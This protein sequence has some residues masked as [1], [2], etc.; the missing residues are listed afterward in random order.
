MKFTLSWLKEHLDTDA[1]VDKIA[2]TL[3]IPQN[4]KRIRCPL[5]GR[6]IKNVIVSP[7]NTMLIFEYQAM[8]NI[9]FCN[10][11]LP[12]A[13]ASWQTEEWTRKKLRRSLK[14][15]KRSST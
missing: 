1:S 15:K 7:D 2:E 12:S 3:V 4:L 9:K 11:D 10:A 14:R 5:G 13:P 6:G 8:N